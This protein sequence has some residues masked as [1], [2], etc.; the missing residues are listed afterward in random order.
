MEK[1]LMFAHHPA[2]SAL[3]PASA[4]FTSIWKQSGNKICAGLPGEGLIAQLVAAVYHR[5]SFIEKLKP[6]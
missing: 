3:S 6:G 5:I 2:P 4:H 1:M